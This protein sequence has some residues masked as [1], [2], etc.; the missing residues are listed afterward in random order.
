MG[1]VED[2]TEEY[3]D[4]DWEEP[5]TTRPASGSGRRVG[6]TKILSVALAVVVVAALAYSGYE[7]SNQHDRI[8]RLQA[9][10]SLQQSA[11]SAATTYGVYLSSYN[12]GDLTGPTAPWTEVDNHA[13]ASFRKDFD[14]T[15]SNLTALINDY[16]ATAVGTV[17]RAAISSATSSR[18]VALLFIDQKI[19]NTA[20][21]PG[22]TVQ[23]LRV[24]LVMARQ[25]GQWLIDQLQV[26]S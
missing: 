1:Y 7:L 3:V 5:A 22:T 24:E 21:K 9:A 16:K 23:P 17:V 8:D 13:T 2:R 11:L 14:S 19:T 25:H 12:Y 10:A 18:A 6:V 4:A 20:Q 26:P 15:R